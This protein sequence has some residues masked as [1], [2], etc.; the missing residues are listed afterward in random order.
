MSRCTRNDVINAFRALPDGAS[1]TTKLIARR[2]GCR[3]YQVRAAISWLVLG[4]LVA[5][6]GS[7]IRTDDKNRK[8]TAKLYTWTGKT[9]ISRVPRDPVDRRIVSDSKNSKT[10]TCFLCRAW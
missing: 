9:E 2:L 6:A 1:T 10:V 8:Y 4:N 3:E 7:T 5:E